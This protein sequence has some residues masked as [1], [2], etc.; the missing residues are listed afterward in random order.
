MHRR[1]GLIAYESEAR[2]GLIIGEDIVL[3]IV[4]PGTNEPV[5]EGEVGEI[6]VTT[7]NPDYPL[8]RFG[9]GDLSAI[10]PG[11]LPAVVPTSGFAAG[12]A[13]RPDDQGAGHVCAPR[14]SG[15]G[16]GPL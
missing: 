13:C 8:L 10:M 4:R 15:Q 7:L 5:P 9:T 1:F 2:D 14:A 12:W 11:I 6:V 3:E 16:R